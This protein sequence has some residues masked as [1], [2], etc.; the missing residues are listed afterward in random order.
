[1]RFSML[2]RDF[3]L[4]VRCLISAAVL[5]AV[6]TAVCAAAA[7]SALSGAERLLSPVQTAVV[8]EERSLLSR[9]VVSTVM[10]MDYVSGVMEVTSC[11]MEEAMDGLETGEFA[12][13][14]VLPEGT[15]DGIMTGREAKGTIYLSPAAASH[16]DIVAKT[17]A[18]GE[19]MLAA[20][21][22]GV[23]SGEQLIWEHGLGDGFY[24]EFLA[25]CNARLISG[26]LEAGGEYF[27]VQVTAYADTNLSTAA[28]YLVCWLAFLVM[29][30]PMLFS[31]LYTRDLQKPVLCRLRGLGVADGAFLLGKAVFPFAF[32]LV[33]LVICLGA[34]GRV[35]ALDITV[36]TVL[37]AVLGVL[38]AA[39]C[40]GGMM[41]AGDNGAP[42]VAAVSAA[43][44]LLCGGLIPRQSLPEFLRILGSVTPVGA[45]QGLFLPVFGGKLTV[46]SV[47]AAVVYAVLLPV[48]V[49]RRL[50]RIRI[51]GDAV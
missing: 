33:L 13:V 49:K 30:V 6:F 42:V 37:C 23:F 45:V 10:R 9:L 41:M 31:A 8:D 14:V 18:F 28:F 50:Q 17:A 3:R 25:E 34:A 20:G 24:Q 46:L 22:Y 47:L 12:A 36:G 29:L 48:F 38:A 5:T 40:G 51:G 21:Q 27:D 11:G 39:L 1:M 35:L 15:M 2:K 44:L 19:L 32:L 16:A 4:F 26:A 43:G 7:F